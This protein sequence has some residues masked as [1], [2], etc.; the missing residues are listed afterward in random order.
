MD[1]SIVSA[2]SAVLGSLVGGSASIATAWFTQKS[3]SSRE[4][5]VSEIRKREIVYTEFIT[6]CSKLSIDSM[7]K[8][9]DSPSVLVQV[10]A[11]QNRIRLSASEPVVA[12]TELTI[13]S[14]VDQY[15]KPNLTMMQL[16]E[17]HLNGDHERADP[18]K[19]FSEACR[20]ELQQLQIGA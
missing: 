15:F 16:H 9:L 11:L 7:D 1:A 2:L 5:V 4:R 18:L 20:A 8:T 10:Y 17:L 3:Q 19:P 13:K 14:I 12:A 6:E